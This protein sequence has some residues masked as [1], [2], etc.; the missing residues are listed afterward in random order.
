MGLPSLCQ[1]ARRS[2]FLPSRQHTHDANGGRPPTDILFD[3]IQ[4]R[5]P[6]SRFH[7][8][9]MD[10]SDRGGLG[11]REDEALQA[12]RALAARLSLKIEGASEGGKEGRM[13]RICVSE[14]NR[15]WEGATAKGFSPRCR[16]QRCRLRPPD[17]DGR[18]YCQFIGVRCRRPPA[19]Q[20]ES[21]APP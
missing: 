17:P 16:R 20:G 21:V 5:L 19:R 11:E 14:G 6:S 10:R 4:S 18:F 1:P 3:R 7:S 15:V 9:W 12:R 2:F 8:R 13:G